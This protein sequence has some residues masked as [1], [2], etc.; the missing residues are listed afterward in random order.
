MTETV[1]VSVLPNAESITINVKKRFTTTNVSG[2][3]VTVR[4]TTRTPKVTG[5]TFSDTTGT[6]NASGNVTLSLVP[7]TYTIIVDS[8]TLYGP[9]TGTLTVFSGGRYKIED[10]TYG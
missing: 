3:T 6:T 8:S 10:V 9:T 7:G 2:M 5:D 4:N 1:Y